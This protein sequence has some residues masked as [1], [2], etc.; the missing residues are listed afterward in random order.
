[1]ISPDTIARV[2][3]R[4]DLV[5]LIG[6]NVRLVRAGRSWK[7]LCPFHKEKSPSFHVSPDRG[8][9]HCFGCQEAGSAVDFVMKVHG[10]DFREAIG[11][12]AERA[13]IQVEETG[14]ADVQKAR[15]ERQEKDELHAILHLAATYY[16]EQ[17]GGW[18]GGIPPS[19]PAIQQVRGHAMAGLARDEVARRGLVFEGDD[20]EATRVRATMAAFRLGYA[21]YGWDGLCSFLRQQGA[22]P[23]IAERAGL[24]VRRSSGSGHYDR[25]RHRLMFAVVDAMGRVVAFSGR[26]LAEPTAEALTRAGVPP[27]STTPAA[28]PPAK[29]VNSPESPVYTKGEHLFGL[30]QARQA[31]RSRGE[32]VLVEGNFDV[33]SLHARGVEHVVAPLGTAFTAS[34]ARLLKRFAPRVIVLFDGD[35]AGR[36]ATR[37][38]RQPCREGGLDAKVALLPRGQDPDDFVKLRGPAALEEVLKRAVGMLE[39]LV[40]EALDPDAFHSASGAERMARVRAVAKLIASEENPDTRLMTKQLADRLS[41]KLILDGQA[42]GDVRHLER[43]VEEAFAEVDRAVPREQRPALV[44]LNTPRDRSPPRWEATPNAIVGAL[45][46]FPELLVDEEVQPALDLVEGD[47]ALAIAA[48]RQVTRQTEA[49]RHMGLDADE[50]LAHVPR[51]IHSFASGRLASPS[52]DA[53][54]TAKAELLENAQL[55]RN[56][57]LARANAADGETLRRGSVDDELAALR[58]VTE[59]A[60]RKRGLD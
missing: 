38:A 16:E 14:G 6:E 34:Q 45:L 21:P 47:Q 9:F 40:G 43:M 11:F 44:H 18:A 39:H 24:I 7:G 17:L 13:G 20:E 56:L 59:R 27:M 60:K 53:V 35:T 25:F 33:F 12:L 31:A 54:A 2:K 3:E 48:L 26:A 55:L 57:I 50:F 41:S 42:P 28:E 58:A 10:L 1:M 51:S 22:S 19:N 15:G 52:F 36:K 4:T 8:F 32:A 37:G 46:D 49:G 30:F 29:Y 5:A 23:L